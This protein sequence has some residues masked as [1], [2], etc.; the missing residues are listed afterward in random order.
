LT[1]TVTKQVLVVK[2]ETLAMSLPS[3]LAFIWYSN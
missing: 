3:M 2:Y 1:Y